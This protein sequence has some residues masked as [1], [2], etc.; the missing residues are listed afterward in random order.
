[1][2]YIV[3]TGKVAVLSVLYLNDGKIWHRNFLYIS[4]NTLQV[5]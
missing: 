1:M 5:I 4:Y 2:D 3:S